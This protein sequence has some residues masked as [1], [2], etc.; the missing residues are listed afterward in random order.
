M[1]RR[2]LTPLRGEKKLLQLDLTRDQIRDLATANE[3]AAHFARRLSGRSSEVAI[4]DDGAR[5][6]TVYYSASECLLDGGIANASDPAL[7]LYPDPPSR[8][9]QD[10]VDPLI[11]SRLRGLNR[12]AKGLKNL[13]QEVFKINATQ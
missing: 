9:R 1:R 3:R 13:L 11:A 12:V 7:R 4:G 6:A 2:V 5:I 8:R 10:E